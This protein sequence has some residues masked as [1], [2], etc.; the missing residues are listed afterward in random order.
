MK[1]SML[2]VELYEKKTHTGAL[3]GNVCCTCVTRKQ[4]FDCLLFVHDYVL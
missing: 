4:D 1:A 2:Q 3:F